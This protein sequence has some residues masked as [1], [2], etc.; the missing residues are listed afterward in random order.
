M[1][2]VADTNVFLAVALDEPERAGILA[3]TAEC[4]LAAP[5][6]LPFEV[7]NALTALVKKGILEPDEILSVWESVQRIPVEL[8]RVNIPGALSIAVERN[9][10]AYDAYF[11]QC[12]MALRSPLLTL[13]QRLRDVA[14]DMGIRLLEVKET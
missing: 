7:G 9:L 1:R 8:R 10:Y 4:D 6:V 12:A 13:D 2:I 11:L 5:D 3:A 14:R